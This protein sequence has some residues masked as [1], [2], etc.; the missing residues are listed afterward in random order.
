M[1]ASLIIISSFVI[2]TSLLISHFSDAL[3]YQSH[4][5]HYKVLKSIE[6]ESRSFNTLFIG[7]SRTLDAV[8]VSLLEDQS[9]KLFIDFSRKWR[10]PGLSY[11]MAQD[12]LKRTKL[13]HIIYEINRTDP[14]RPIHYRWHSMSTYSLLTSEL[15]NNTGEKAFKKLQQ[16]STSLA[17]KL[18]ED[19]NAILS[20][21]A[22]KFEQLSLSKPRRDCS[23]KKS[24][25]RL[26]LLAKRKNDN[27]KNKTDAWHFDS[28]KEGRNNYYI[29]KLITLA[30][31]H[32]TKVT[33]VYYNYSFSPPLDPQFVE[34]IEHHYG[35]NLLYIKS[36]P[37]LDDLY[38]NGFRDQTH[39][40]SYGQSIFAKWLLQQEL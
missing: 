36:V 37:V 12:V 31:K 17:R 19:L 20:S 7:S 8:N 32:S 15:F 24:A 23:P 5:C 38:K 22:Y 11:V 18:T 9:S 28:I 35:V 21:K 33:F 30:K 29:K 1:R 39:M 6:A 40:N 3:R 13:N 4:Q 34:K 10:S 14:K 2:V 25:V 16:F 26:D 27:W